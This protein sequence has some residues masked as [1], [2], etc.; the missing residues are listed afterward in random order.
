MAN[1]EN[2]QCRAT[3]FNLLAFG[4]KTY[5][6]AVSDIEMNEATFRQLLNLM[7][8]EFSEKKIQSLKNNETGQLK[9]CKTKIKKMFKLFVSNA[10]F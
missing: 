3:F 6:E 1:L 2:L 10:E 7:F 9:E 8:R 5:E 4:Y